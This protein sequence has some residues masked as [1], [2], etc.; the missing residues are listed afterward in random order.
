MVVAR[1][2]ITG[3]NRRARQRATGRA[4]DVRR[5]GLEVERTMAD[6]LLVRGADHVLVGVR[7][8]GFTV[9][10]A[11]RP[12]LVAGASARL[13]A[14]LPPQHV[15][16]E[17]SA[18]GSPAP[19]QLSNPPVPV[20]RAALS[21][22][23][24]VAFAVAPGT[25]VP[26]TVAGVLAAMSAAT[27]H[28]GGGTPGP[29]DT[30]I[31]L[32]WRLVIVPAG[33]DGGAVHCVQPA[34]FEAGGVTGLWHLALTG[35]TATAHDAGLSVRPVGAGTDAGIAFR[36]ALN[37]A[38]RTLITANSATRLP[39]ASALELGAFGGTLSADGRWD[40]F[41]W[42]QRTRLGRDLSV[43]TSVT[44]RLFPFGHTAV[45]QEI[46]ERVFDPSAGHAA[47]LRQ[48]AVLT[49]SDRIRH[50]PADPATR[51]RF[52][53][54]DVEILV[55][56]AAELGEPGWQS[57]T[58]PGG[59]TA[60][61][62]WFWPT[63]RAGQPVAFPVRIAAPAGDIR[64]S[65]PLIFVA[66]HS[67]GYA[68]LADTA[69][70][71]TLSAAYAS[72]S[73]PVPGTSLDLVCA[74]TRRAGD[75]HEVHA[76]RMA[77]G[78]AADGYRP[79]LDGLDVRVPALRSLTGFDGAVPVR[80]AARYLDRGEAEDVVLELAGP[81]VSVDFTRQADRSGGLT[82]PNFSANALS[83]TFGPVNRNALP[84]QVTGVLDPKALFPADAT[85]LGF[86]LRDLVSG[87]KAPPQITSLPQAAG[88]P[89]EV[90]MRW[91]DVK[92]TRFGPFVPTTGS[93]LNL[94]VITTPGPPEDPAPRTHTSCT[95]NDFALILP[96]GSAEPLLK[97]S[98][99]EIE[100]VQDSGHPPDLRIEGLET[101]FLGILELLKEVPTLVD[102]VS[103][104][105]HLDPSPTGITASYILPIPAVSAGAF[106][107]RNIGVAVSIEV[108]FDGRP[109]RLMLGFSTRANPFNLS[110][111]ALGG[112]G[113]IELELDRDGLRRLEIALE[114]GAL[115]A[116]DFLVAHGEVHALGGIRFALEQD[117]SVSLE[118]YLR[119]GGCVQVLGLISVSVEMRIGLTYTS[120]RKALVGRATL[121]VEVDLTLWSESVELD[122]GEWVLAG[123]SAG[124]NGLALT[125]GETVSL[126][127]DRW[128]DYLAV[129]AH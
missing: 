1:P 59:G 11:G 45:Y 110:V 102:L 123:G 95:V 94:T 24:R 64:C 16:E 66:D 120:A 9:Q 70:A 111:L 92:L 19:L 82:S 54:D 76:L 117:G 106:S 7:C 17:V 127:A 18:P 73:I 105:K 2:P 57:Q 112:G 5:A 46:A 29:D 34:T 26:L 28:T 49:I 79:R 14:I 25:V 119:I 27:V 125:A 65:L 88:R 52:P 13:V 68:S 39:V 69:L 36:V 97:V 15:A 72:R 107:L 43:R 96:A 3:M 124:D 104:A 128:R 75:V 101:E 81:P 8:L 116:I 33:R 67:P 86:P 89:P 126:D 12:R 62:T 51:R 100:F 53:F 87:V 21:G 115:V 61:P 6:L 42:R 85:L 99:T 41:E 31:E 22:G 118:G 103:A 109:V 56:E 78:L 93:R 40:N 37:A 38:E 77:G 80:F 91:D 84:N 60:L 90:T 121:V 10:T 113:Y 83:R 4:R 108:P 50:A 114:F 98:F 47:V 55:G 23:S 129:F 58:P 20:W 32:P 30:A 122:S 74:A 44:G 63:N 35:R 71:G 48:W